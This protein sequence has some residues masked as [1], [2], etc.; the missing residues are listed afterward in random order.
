MVVRKYEFFVQVAKAISHQQTTPSN[1]KIIS[2]SQRV[3]FFNDI[4]I[5][6]EVNQ[7]YKLRTN[8]T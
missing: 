5:S 1:I 7:S 8:R 4:N 6:A 3:M 2:S